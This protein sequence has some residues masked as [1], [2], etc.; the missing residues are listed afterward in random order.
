MREYLDRLNPEKPPQVF[1]RR[2]GDAGHHRLPPAGHARRHRGHPR[3]RRRH[4]RS[5]SSSRTAAGSKPSA[6]ARRRGARRCTRRRASSSTTSGSRACDQLPT[7]EGAAPLTALLEAASPGQASLLQPDAAAQ[8]EL[9]IDANQR[10]RRSRAK[11]PSPIPPTPPAQRR[12]PRFRW[13]V[14]HEQKSR[15][16]MPV[17][18]SNPADAAAPGATGEDRR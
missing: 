3:R 5:S 15:L 1:A 11:Q 7:V 12:L 16:R 10:R 9:V 18:D 17:T 8:A 13:N 14:K 6:I 4:A 2:D